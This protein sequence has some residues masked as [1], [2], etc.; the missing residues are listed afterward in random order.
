[1]EQDGEILIF[2]DRADAGRRLAMRLARYREENPSVIALPRGGVAVGY[3]I[4]HA[5]HAPLDVIV[6]RKLGVPGREEL[7]LGAIAPGGVRVLDEG[8]IDW[9]GISEAQLERIIARETAEMERR[10]RL[11]RGGD[12]PPEVTGRT[13]ILADDG[14]ATGVTARAA[15]LSLRQQNP[16]RLVLAVPVCAAET[17][18]ALRSQVDDLV[19]ASTPLNFRAVGFWYEDFTQVTD[20]AVTVLLARARQE[21]QE[22]ARAGS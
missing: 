17:A 22:P 15:V 14:L 20:E 11:Y 9:F 6:A 5:F 8:I 19:C 4:A 12:A 3:E 1:M 7:G 16:R 10:L 13:V 21:A 2:H 18:E